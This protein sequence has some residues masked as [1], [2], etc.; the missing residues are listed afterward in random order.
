MRCPQ[1]ARTV[2]QDAPF[3]TC[4]YPVFWDERAERSQ[5]PADEQDLSRT[6]DEQTV[7]PPSRRTVRSADPAPP[8]EQLA[9]L[10]A[11]PDCDTPN[12]AT[13]TL[14][15]RCG[16]TLQPAEPAAPPPRRRAVIP[17]AALVVVVVLVLAVLAWSLGAGRAG[18]AGGEPAGV[19]TPSETTEEATTTPSPMPTE[20]ATA[21]HVVEQGETLTTIAQRYGTT[22]EALVEANGITNPDV[23]GLGQELLIPA[24]G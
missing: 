5:T 15:Q 1:C 22:V 21:T 19:A 20:P 23:I 2:E 8:T 10:L 12:P 7:P 9:A 18:R 14:C 16:A 17:T 24:P 13:R 3:C 6:P 4:G 11:C